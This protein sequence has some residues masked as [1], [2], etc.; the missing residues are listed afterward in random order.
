MSQQNLKQKPEIRIGLNILNRRNLHEDSKHRN[1][2]AGFDAFFL[3]HV[4]TRAV[5]RGA[6]EHAPE[7]S[8]VLVLLGA[9]RQDPWGFSKDV[10]YRSGN[11]G[12]EYVV[13]QAIVM[14]RQPKC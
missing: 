8:L 14:S 7:R 11:P 5:P 6:K 13:I 10:C 12:G 3:N 1:M 2:F 4:E 9:K